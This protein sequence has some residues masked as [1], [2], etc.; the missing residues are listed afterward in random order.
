MEED[1]K[2]LND[3]INE[4]K[5]NWDKT[6]KVKPTPKKPTPKWLVLFFFWSIIFSLVGIIFSAIYRSNVEKRNQKN[7]YDLKSEGAHNKTKKDTAEM[8]KHFIETDPQLKKEL[9]NKADVIAEKEIKEKLRN[10]SLEEIFKSNIEFLDAAKKL[11]NT[12]IDD[13]SKPYLQE[14]LRLEIEIVSGLINS[15][16][17]IVPRSLE[18]LLVQL[19]A[20]EQEVISY[21][22]EN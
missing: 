20:K 16:K 10:V 5:S 12:K 8:I 14:G 7:S 11:L 22:N 2:D 4:I 17:S 21:K 1:K 9:N 6:P 18:N 15:Q 3:L 19:K 13:S